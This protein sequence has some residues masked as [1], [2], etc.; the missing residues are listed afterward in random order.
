MPLLQNPLI[1]GKQ[2]ILSP[3]MQRHASTPLAHS[4]SYGRSG[5]ECSHAPRQ[6]ACIFQFRIKPHLSLVLNV[7][8]VHLIIWNSTLLY[9]LLGLF[10]QLVPL[11]SLES[12]R[13][14]SF[15]I[16][17]CCER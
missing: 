7:S 13:E 6:N 9:Y 10:H 16:L 12:P 11:E 1:I 17:P 5:V 14:V 15:Q 2:N 4:Q 3:V 8:H